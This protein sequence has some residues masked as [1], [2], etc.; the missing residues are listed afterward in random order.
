MIFTTIKKLAAKVG[1]NLHLSTENG[2]HDASFHTGSRSWGT[3]AAMAAVAAV[4]GK[5]MCSHVRHRMLF[6]YELKTNNA[7]CESP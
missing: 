2:T 4:A 6:K 3:V 1:G 5:R 7:A